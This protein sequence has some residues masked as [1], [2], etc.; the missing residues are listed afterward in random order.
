MSSD[1]SDQLVDQRLAKRKIP[2]SSPVRLCSCDDLRH[3][4]TNNTL[5]R[6]EI[7]RKIMNP[8]MIAPLKL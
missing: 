7:P 8:A 3:S 5:S 6:K 1:E 4:L 2:E